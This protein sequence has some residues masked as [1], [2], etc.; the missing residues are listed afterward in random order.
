MKLYRS[1]L[2]KFIDLPS[3]DPAVLRR[4][5]DDV[6]LEVKSIEARGHDTLFTIET[7]ANRGDHLSALGV[8]RELAARLLCHTKLP[9]F[10][11]I[12]DQKTHVIVRK[13]TELCLRYALL[14]ITTPPDI[15]LRDEIAVTLESDGK[16]HP[17]VDI[18]NYAALELGQ[19]MHAFDKEKVD[20][21]I[22]VDEL[23]AAESIDALDGKSYTVPAGS[24]VIRDRKKILAVAGVIGC[25]N[26]MVEKQTTRILIE[27]ATFDPV[28]VRKT[29]RAM[30]LSTDASHTFERGAD[31]EMVLPALRRALYLT[32]DGT[33]HSA[34]LVGHVMIEGAPVEKRVVTV[35]LA[36]LKHQVNA[37]RLNESE[38]FSRLKNLGY[39]I[40]Y[41]A[42]AKAKTFTVTVP[43]W[44]LWDVKNEEDIFED[45]ARSHGLNEIK[46]KLPPLD[47][48][49]AEKHPQD[50]FFEHIEPALVGAGFYEV[51]TKSFYS[52]DDAACI[53]AL[54]KQIIGQHVTLKNSLES[55]FSHL[56]TTSILHLAALAAQ[57]IKMGMQS[58]KVFEL[59]RVFRKKQHD[60]DDQRSPE[61]T[62]V[63]ELDTLSMLVAGRW[64]DTQW[65][66]P[67]SVAD[68]FAY[69]KGVTENLFASLNRSVTLKSSKHPLMHPGMQAH[70]VVGRTTVGT[71]GVLHPHLAARYELKVP[72][73]FVEIATADLLKPV[74]VA[75]YREPHDLP[76]MR[77]DVTLAIPEHFFAGD[78]QRTIVHGEFQDLIDVQITDDFKK[79]DE[80]F[81]RVTYRMTFQNA[82]RTLETATVDATMKS[83]LSH[84]ESKHAVQ[85]ALS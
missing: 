16:K 54:D 28:R 80:N 45:F 22:I 61:D 40:S 29:A 53:E 2:E 19:P 83:V 21:E 3:Q 49:K 5:L 59:A 23:A 75:P 38:L 64:F 32:Q 67:E 69:T 60:S 63:V 72:T 9:S 36:E 18:L 44:R 1:I 65:K 57:N 50:L 73:V 33:A 85:C 34:Q 46:Q 70:L 35:R 31:V 37:P 68:L 43:S 4:L 81:R 14:E 51:I 58:V 24:V 15:K 76:V 8:A 82:V 17:I 42:A 77:R 7:L 10:A 74:E 25:A 13:Q 39:H 11:N 12:G 52:A 62:A 27:S 20:G 47:Y 71:I 79:S 48:E 56:R 55:S 30:G 84:L 41:D 66:Q 78:I 6:G 26:S